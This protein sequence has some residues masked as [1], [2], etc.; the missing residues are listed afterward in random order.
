VLAD[1]R[2]RGILATT[3]FIVT[4]TKRTLKMYLFLRGDLICQYTS[5]KSARHM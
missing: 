5:Y 3:P 1:P 4:L 2:R